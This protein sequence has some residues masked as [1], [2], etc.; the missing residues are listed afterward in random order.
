MY[1]CTIAALDL[2]K[3]GCKSLHIWFNY[4]ITFPFCKF[5]DELYSRYIIVTIGIVLRFD[6]IGAI[7][8]N[9]ARF[10][11]CCYMYCLIINTLFT[12]DCPI[13]ITL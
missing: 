13:N 8:Y 5:V 7:G 12:Y 6:W 4:V 10:V 3:N 1:I 11:R 9:E 2:C